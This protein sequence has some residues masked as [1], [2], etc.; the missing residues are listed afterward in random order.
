MSFAVPADS[1]VRDNRFIWGVATA[2]F[3][4]E[5]A[6]HADGRVDSIWDTFCAEPG[7]VLNGDNGEPACDHYHRWEQDLDLLSELGVDAYRFSIAWPRIMRAPGE[8]NEAGLAFYERLV[9]GL[10]DRGIRPVATLYH[11]DLP[12]YLEDHGGWLNRETAYEFARYAQVVVERLGNKVT[13]WATLNEPLCS[14]FLSYEVGV[15]APGYREPAWAYQAAHHLLLAHGLAMPVMRAAAPESQHGIVLNFTPAYA[16]DDRPETQ[17]AVQDAEVKDVHWFIAPLM[18][19]EYPAGWFERFPEWRPII[20]PGDMD[21]IRQ[22]MDFVGVNFYTRHL[23]TDDGAGGVKHLPQP[24]AEH[25]HI[26]WEVYPEAL[27]RT[28]VTLH[29]SY[30]NLPPL[31]ITENGMAGDDHVVDGQVNDAQRVSYLERHITAVGEAMRQGVNIRGYFA[32][33]LM[34]NFEWAF[35]YSQR[36]GLVYVDYETQERIVKR[37]GQMLKEW[38]KEPRLELASA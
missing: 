28:L 20:M 38:M 31:I 36:F 21:L 9:D 3:Q 35:G 25:T 11:W 15:H 27:T 8:V 17:R 13:H 12:Q 32:W 6:I 23:V 29:R 1:P 33:S 14:S 10:I 37:S 7:R 16:A 5:G 22:P 2:A 34:D 26:G 30:Q 4:I 19:G 18:Q 24:D